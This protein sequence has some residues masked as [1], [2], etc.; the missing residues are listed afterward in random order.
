LRKCT[1]SRIVIWGHQRGNSRSIYSVVCIVFDFFREQLGA[2][3]DVCGDSQFELLL[4][5][6]LSFTRTLFS[7]WLSTERSDL[8]NGHVF[9]VFSVSHSRVDE[10]AQARPR[11]LTA[12]VTQG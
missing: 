5:T 3:V 12:I 2:V 6:L 9:P 1:R 10:C 11:P 4:P 7:P 8:R